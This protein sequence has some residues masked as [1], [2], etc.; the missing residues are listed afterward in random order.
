MKQCL[1]RFSSGNPGFEVLVDG[2]LKLFSDKDDSDF[3]EDDN[4]VQ[5][6]NTE[7]EEI[8]YAQLLEGKDYL[9]YGPLRPNRTKVP[10]RLPGQI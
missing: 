7:E 1:S 8:N 2:D 6:D 10:V 3:N 4:Y 5:K 9:F